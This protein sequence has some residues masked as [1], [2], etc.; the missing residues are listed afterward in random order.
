MLAYGYVPAI[1]ML[2]DTFIKKVLYYHTY[3]YMCMWNCEYMFLL[4][5]LLLCMLIYIFIGMLSIVNENQIK[6]HVMW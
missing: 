1:F 6:L 2:I 3:I 5:V 4:A